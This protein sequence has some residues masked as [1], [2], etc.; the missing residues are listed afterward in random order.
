MIIPPC[1]EDSALGLLFRAHPQPMY[2]VEV[3]SLRFLDV[4]DAAIEQYGW[5]HAEW[6]AMSLDDIRPPPE[7]VRLH[8]Y[9]GRAGANIPHR[10]GI[11]QHQRKDGSLLHVHISSRPLRYQGC[12]ARLVLT[13]DLTGWLETEQARESALRA[14][15]RSE[16][17]LLAAQSIAQLGSFESDVAGDGRMVCSAQLL[18]LIGREPGS[19]PVVG[20]AQLMAHIDAR[21]L[22]SVRAFRRSVLR[23]AQDGQVV[24]RYWCPNGQMCWLVCRTETETDRHGRVL[25]VRGTLQDITQHKNSEARLLMLRDQ[26]RELSAQRE[27]EIDRERKRIAGNLHDGLG[28]LLS[29]I[30]LQLEL[31]VQRCA[32]QGDL[33]EGLSTGLVKLG[34][35]VEDSLDMTRNFSMHLRPP[36]LDLGLVP[37]LE[38]LADEF[39]VR[40]EIPCT[41]T[42]LGP[43]D[44]VQALDEDATN[45]LFRVVQESLGNITRHASARQVDIRLESATEALHLRVQ[46]DG[47]GFDPEQARNKGHFG[48]FGMRERALRLGA[49]LDIASQPGQGAVVALH[50]PWRHS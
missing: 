30:K 21:D 7:V 27:H 22:E 26:L 43:Q 42:V 20:M 2:V 18:R 10:A 34:E 8:R 28:Q 29:S 12:D 5:S 33:A 44:R 50:M 31:L 19:H 49:Q 45:D 14:L 36:A 40:A 9:I 35:L 37:A 15:H 6:L 46:D 41:L 23:E 11:W 48:L 16:A 47:C 39:R 25:R 1:S 24:F 13:Q 17:S 3:S 32:S 38:W 4:N